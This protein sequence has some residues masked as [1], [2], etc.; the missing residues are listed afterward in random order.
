MADPV[1][2]RQPPALNERQRAVLRFVVQYAAQ[3]DYAPTIREIQSGLRISSSSIVVG[4]LEV[5][6]ALGYIRRTPHVSRSIVVLPAG[7][8]AL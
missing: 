8:E 1:A 7:H 4:R 6:Q 3:H 5:L 2:T